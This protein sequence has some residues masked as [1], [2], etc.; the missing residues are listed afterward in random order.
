MEDKRRE[1]EQLTRTFLEA[2][3]LQLTPTLSEMD[4]SFRIDL[5]G[6]DA[7]L[8]LERRASTLE[9][10]QFIL[11]KVAERR[12][13]LDKRVILDCAG[14]RRAR[15]HELAQIAAHAAEKVRKLGEPL[16]LSPMNPY[17]RR[18]VHLALREEQGVE[19]VSQGEGFLKR[20]RILPT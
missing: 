12:L 13:D 7:D 6:T 10:L 19:S 15:D 3:R 17:E 5:E 2:M 9:S 4:D 11:G 8:L 18:L 16:D 1:L 20:I 14:Y